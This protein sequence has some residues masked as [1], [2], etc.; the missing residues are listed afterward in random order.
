M[1]LYRRGGSAV[2]VTAFTAA[3]A[4]ASYH[5]SQIWEHGWTDLQLVCT[6]AFAWLAFTSILPYLHRDIPQ[7]HPGTHAAA[8]L[9]RLFVTV[10]V[11]AHNEDHAMFQAFLDSL[12]RQT[13]LPNRLHVVENGDPGYVFTLEPILRAWQAAGRHR[14][15]DVRYSTNDVGDKREAQAVAFR[16]DHDADI[17]VT[18]DS[19]VKLAPTAIAAGLAAFRS[20]RT[21][22]VTGMLVG[23]NTDTNLLTRLIEPAFVCAYLN[24]RAAH[25]MLRSV[26]V[27]SG[28]LSF[29]RAAIWHKYLD[30]YLNHTVAGRKLKDGDDSMMTCYSL[31]EGEAL[32]QSGCWGYTLHP[33]RLRQLTSQRVRWWRSLF[34]GGFWLL[35]VFRPT[36]FAWWSTAWDLLS[37]TWMTVVIPFVLIVRP[38]TTGAAPWMVGV[39]AVALT[40]V[41]HARYLTLTRPGEPFW[42]HLRLWL[43]SPLAAVL[44]FY[45]GFV[46]SYVGLFTCLKGGWSSRNQVVTYQATAESRLPRPPTPSYDDDGTAGTRDL[47]GLRARAAQRPH[48]HAVAVS[49]GSVPSPR[50]SWDDEV[51][52]R[53]LWTVPR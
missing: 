12:S 29:Y 32:F 3:A 15:I 11:P 17:I 6:A 46:L 2:A 47:A 40:Y 44:N 42:S 30:H 41:T 31:L 34:W 13:R 37:M 36:R 50:R 21:A 14:G 18:V 19:D 9:D 5:A 7:P 48:G 38:V 51:E 28:A 53:R 4:L 52:T 8:L 33:D 26:T 22:C 49:G 35:R 20:S 24:G 43:L 27:N 45:T 16:Q 39:W 25:S 10:I 23:L 1:G